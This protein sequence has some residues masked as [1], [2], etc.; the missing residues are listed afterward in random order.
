MSRTRAFIEFFKI[1]ETLRIPVFS[2]V[3]YKA[4]TKL[5]LKVFNKLSIPQNPLNT[6]KRE[7]TII[8]SLTS[9]PARIDYVDK[10]I[11]SLM[12]QTVKP[13]RIIL[14]LAN[15]QFPDKKLPEELTRLE[16]KGLE[17]CWC[18]DLYGHKKYFYPVKNQKE[19]EVVITFDDDI[20][21]SPKAIE[22]LMKTHKKFPGCLVCERAQARE[23]GLRDI[24]NPGKWKTISNIGVKFPSYSLNPSPGGGC[25]IPYKAFCEDAINEEKIRQLAYKNDDLWYMFMCAANGTRTV[26][27]RKYHKI[28]TLVEGSQVVQMATENVVGN[29][30]VEIMNGLIEAYPEAYK[31]IMTDKD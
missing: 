29:K 6:E 3:W 21:Y 23:N 31:R 28:F 14:W 17:I 12:L 10:A 24:E 9:F 11:K 18:H 15:E 2:G 27:T 7:E 25:L 13:D 30:N 1:Y 8:C 22:R 26:K 20:V 5:D 19:N 16:E 4:L